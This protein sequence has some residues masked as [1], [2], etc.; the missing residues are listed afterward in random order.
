MWQAHEA[1]SILFLLSLL[2]TIKLPLQHQVP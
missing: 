1:T 2:L